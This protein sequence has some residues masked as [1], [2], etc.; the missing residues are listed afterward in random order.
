[1]ATITIRN[2]DDELK[3]SLRIAAAR[4]GNSMEEEVRNILSKA[5]QTPQ[6]KGGLG[7][8]INQR[9]RSIGGVDL[10]ISRPDQPRAADIE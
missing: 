5:L 4:H 1:M 9:F 8:R 7:S 10:E 6:P 2:L 3:A